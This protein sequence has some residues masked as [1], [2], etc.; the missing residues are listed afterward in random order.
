MAAGGPSI[1]F[2]RLLRWFSELWR[3]DTDSQMWPH[4]RQL[5]YR[6]WGLGERAWFHSGHAQ[7]EVAPLCHL[8][9]EKVG[10]NLCEIVSTKMIMQTASLKC[11]GRG[12]IHSR[13]LRALT[14]AHTGDSLAGPQSSPASLELPSHSFLSLTLM[15]Y[16]LPLPSC[17][18]SPEPFWF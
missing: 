4:Q 8:Q 13:G 12:S 7:A 9:C 5:P 11:C 10:C 17:L 14:P 15:S 3:R 16:P 2:E 6:A 1:R 18:F